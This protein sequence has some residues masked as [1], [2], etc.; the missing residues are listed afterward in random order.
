MDFFSLLLYIKNILLYY[1]L[2]FPRRL[3]HD[4]VLRAKNKFYGL[5]AATM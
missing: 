5:V 1:L 4:F 2:G 3:I